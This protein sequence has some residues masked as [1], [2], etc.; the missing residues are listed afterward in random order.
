MVQLGSCNAIWGYM[1]INEGDDLLVEDFLKASF[2]KYK[3]VD[4]DM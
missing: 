2:V 1:L 3:L 4:W